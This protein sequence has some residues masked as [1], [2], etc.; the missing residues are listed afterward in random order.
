MEYWLVKKALYGLVTSPRDWCV[1]RD[2]KIKDFKW[3]TEHTQ[4]M[5]ER[6]A[7]DDVW[8]IKSLVEGGEGWQLAGLCSTYVDDILITGERKVIEQF[9]QRV[10]S[11]E[12]W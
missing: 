8:A 2:Q 10:R 6:T 3:E 11:L 9:H 12:N 4:Y 7:Q 5:M 1:H